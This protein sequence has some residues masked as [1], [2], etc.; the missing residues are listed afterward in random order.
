MT[1]DDP[2]LPTLSAVLNPVELGEHL[3][4]F[5]PLP[6][7]GSNH[8]QVRVLRHHPGKRC[9]VEVTSR[10]TEGPRAL[11]GKVYA[12]DR[13]DVYRL[14]EELRRAGF[15]P[16]DQYTIPQPV[17]YLPTLHLLLQE[18][19]E[20]RAATGPFLSSNAAERTAAAV[21][22]ARWLIKFHATAPPIGPRFP[23]SDHLLTLE[24]WFRRVAALGEP[25]AGK[26][27]ELFKG[28]E[29]AAS[30]LPR[31]ELRTI[32]GDY[33]HHQVVLARGRAVGVDWDDYGR[34][35]PCHEVARFTVG[36]QRLAQRR[37]G[38]MRAL[39]GPAEVF[40]ETYV[41]A[42]LSDVRAR[43]AFQRAAI[44]LEHAKHDVH[45]RA[46]GWSERAEATLDEGLRV[47]NPG[48]EVNSA[49]A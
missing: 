39:D 4:E 43:L 34:A 8:L 2:A 21:L 16:N 42:G 24:Q 32:H 28:L 36:L 27:G 30:V 41:A 46:P 37:C 17:A 18:K 10:T 7:K 23:L 3:R 47:L 1:F 48:V 31:G 6:A 49:R 33:A 35:D 38:S 45:K 9:V 15:G 26:A 13:S 11:I 20:G 40:V 14:M 29:A 19:V 44:C 25:F 12:K 22:C 5:L